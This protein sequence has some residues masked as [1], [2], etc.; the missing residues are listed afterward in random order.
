VDKLNLEK[1]QKDAKGMENKAEDRV[2]KNEKKKWTEIAEV[3]MLM[4]VIPVGIALALLG[5]F[6]SQLSGH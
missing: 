6:L 1:I 3:R 2:E 4:Y 5:L